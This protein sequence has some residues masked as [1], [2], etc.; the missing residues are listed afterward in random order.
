MDPVSSQ[1][2]SLHSRMLGTAA[3]ALNGAARRI[4][5]AVSK[6]VDAWVNTPK[7][8][9]L[10]L[11]TAALLYAPGQWL[12][13][14]GA[15]AAVT[16]L[17]ETPKNLAAFLCNQPVQYVGERWQLFDIQG[18]PKDPRAPLSE[19]D[20]KISTFERALPPL[21][22]PP[23]PLQ[24]VDA[25]FS[26]IEA[27]AATSEMEKITDKKLDVLIEKVSYLS[28]FKAMQSFS[29]VPE[30]IGVPLL[31][32][33]DEA[34]RTKNLS[35]WNI[36][37]SHFGARMSLWGRLKAGIVYLFLWHWIPVLPKIVDAYM[38]NMLNELR[39]NLR[40]NGEKRKKF[41]NGLLEEADNF[42]EVYN[43]AAETYAN[44]NERKGNL[45]HYRKN[46]IDHIL[47]KD[48]SASLKT[49]Q[50]LRMDL[51]R[52][53]SASIVDHFSP[54]IR[55]GMFDGW[56]N[57]TIRNLLQGKILPQVFLNVSDE[58]QEATKRYN[59]PFFLALTKTLTAQISKI[60]GKSEE[61]PTD[62]SLL[63]GIKNFEAIVKKIL[64]TIDM[65]D[66]KTP[67]EVRA[68]MEKLKKPWTG[69]DG[70]VRNGIQR[71]IQKGLAVLCDY[72]SKQENTEE[73]FASLFESV[74][75]PLSGHLPMTDRQWAEVAVEY[76]GAKILLKQAGASLAKQF[77]QASVQDKVRGSGKATEAA[78]NAAKGIFAEHQ[79]RGRETFEE[80]LRICDTAREKL[81]QPLSPE[82][83]IYPELASIASVLKAFEN[84]ERVKI[85]TEQDP[86]PKIATLPAA[87]QEAI[88][89]ILHPLYEG[90]NQMMDLVLQLQNLQK[91]YVSHTGVTRELGEIREALEEIASYQPSP[92]PFA[93]I[94]GIAARFK[95]IETLDPGAAVILGSLKEEID[96][97]ARPLL[98]IARIHRQESA[99]ES[100]AQEK[101][102]GL[103]EELALSL[104]N[105]PPP[106]FKKRKCLEEIK[107]NVKMASF[108][109]IEECQ[110]ME[111]IDKMSQ[112][113]S[114]PV[115]RPNLQ[116]EILE[117]LAALLRARKTSLEKDRKRIV[118][119]LEENL[120]KA[121]ES[122]EFEESKSNRSCQNVLN[123]MQKKGDLL[124]ANVWRLYKQIEQ[125]K[126]ETLLRPTPAQLGQ[127]GGTL[128]FLLGMGLGRHSLE[129]A[130]AGA[131]LA[132]ASGASVY[133]LG[134]FPNGKWLRFSASVLSAGAASFFATK[135]VSEAAQKAFPAYP[136]LPTLIGAA[137]T[138]AGFEYLGAKITKRI[139]DTGV[140]VAMPKVTEIFDAAYEHVL[141]NDVIIN[142][143]IKI[144]MK[145]IVDLFPPKK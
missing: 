80:L 141:T 8:I 92:A 42:F 140:D 36:F 86:P 75:S 129:A 99:L 74:A 81:H 88:L 108:N 138:A 23:L 30:N 115:P 133:S 33:V 132:A 57:K 47:P 137:G 6:T 19:L 9:K 39:I 49:V 56:L 2:D 103:I 13:P 21:F 72:L 16:V 127:I 41:I 51:Y 17:T 71:G 58:G 142:G 85:T 136:M 95:N 84:K 48:E 98:Q 65:A 29:G 109:M 68:K 128:G 122:S 119:F 123:E 66:C 101:S 70:E 112:Y 116:K 37:T 53:L 102:K 106:G 28:I 134:N 73:L 117:P 143:G 40:E 10:P 32:L 139:I 4:G 20:K 11:E 15:I 121:H 89:R 125:A 55:F 18:F 126:K 96:Q 83:N 114:L 44:D 113:N 34:S 22:T 67:E 124:E 27:A 111:L 100:L 78:E 45:N 110:I 87:E 43:G 135:Y 131:A 61:E 26:P 97:M 130:S 46:A 62:A 144:L 24:F 107:K 50:E 38:K 145:Q 63:Y 105:N 64:W 120:Q 52:K 91:Q 69:I 90:S 93:L 76:E 7:A 31:C 77:I 35:L 79:D 3:W 25:S 14:K 82:M 54:R 94:E 118:S 59:I 5:V 1:R 104:Q 60:Q 12:G